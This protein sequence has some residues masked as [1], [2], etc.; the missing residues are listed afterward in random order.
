MADITAP[1]RPRG[2]DWGHSRA[3]AQQR[4][5]Q[6]GVLDLVH[7]KKCQSAKE[8]KSNEQV[9][10]PFGD[11][12]VPAVLGVLQDE[13]VVRHRRPPTKPGAKSIYGKE[14]ANASLDSKLIP[15]FSSLN[16]FHIKKTEWDVLKGLSTEEKVEALN[17]KFVTAGIV[18]TDRT[19]DEDYL[20]MGRA[21]YAI[22]IGGVR[23]GVLRG[24]KPVMA[25]ELL[26]WSVP[27]EYLDEETDNAA[28]RLGK[29]KREQ[30]QDG[31]EKEK[32]IFSIEPYDPMN[33]VSYDVVKKIL[34]DDFI[35]K[36]AAT[37]DNFFKRFVIP[38]ATRPSYGPNRLIGMLVKF[39]KHV[40][41]VEL[42][43]LRP[44]A[45]VHAAG[46]YDAARYDAAQAL[47]NNPDP[48]NR[49][50]LYAT[51]KQVFKD[52]EGF[53]HELLN[54]YAEVNYDYNRRVFG[55]ALSD[56]QPGMMFD[57]KVGFYS[58]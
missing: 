36:P 58:L 15:C 40:T 4:V 41:A 56:A 47:M 27:R 38:D 23:S 57:Y 26:V 31:T 21:D 19:Y 11:N 10:F 49:A 17:R 39:I 37:A 48:A 35:E 52:Q 12:I 13:V 53:I 42:G 5:A 20:N 14:P 16:G 43:M 6:N 44:D 25:G 9:D 34:Y 54:V 51:I 30:F 3:V 24:T 28:N 50:S 29:R 8:N 2:G 55:M 1:I 45:V 33:T 18:G 46:D 32:V 7:I 22:E